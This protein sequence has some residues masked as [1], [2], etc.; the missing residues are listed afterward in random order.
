[1]QYETAESLYTQLE[2]Q[3]WTFLDR[4][5][6][7]SE[8]TIPY[9]LP[10]D[11]HG[12]HTKYYTPYQGIGARGVNNLASKLLLA[13]L[14]PNAPFFRLVIDRYEL[15]KAKA[16]MGEEGGEQLRT[17]L[18]KALS[19]VER[20]VSQEVEVE[21]FRVGVFE[22]LKNLLIT[23]NT[24]LY[25]PD[26]GGMRV[27]RPDR[28]V[29]KR[30]A[31]GNVT[32]IAVKETVAPF[33]LPEEVR[34]EVYKESKDNNCDL[35]TS[36]CREGDKFVVKQDVKGIVIEE[37]IGEYPIDKSP[38]LPLRYT[39]IDGEDY[40][41]GFVEEYLGDLKSLEAL[42]KAI[43]EGSAAAA[44]VLFMINPNGTTRARTLAEAPNGAIVQGSDG[45]VSV[46]QLNKFN[47][48]RVAQSVM[49]Q[50][51]DRLSHAFLL[52]SSVVRDA[53]RVTAEE[54]RMLSQELE[55]ALGGLYSILSQE[56]QLPLVTRLMD[57][58]S[59]KD[60]LPKLPKDIVKPTIVT[61]IEALGRGNDLN[62]LDMFLA[63]AN[64]VV[65]PQAVSQYVNVGD[66]F[67]RRATALGIETEGLIKSDEEIQ[68]AMQQAQQQEMMMK[69]GAPAVA[70]TIN[71]IAQQQQGE[72]AVEEEQ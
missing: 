33:M 41:R 68:M 25:L 9:V 43:V 59:K 48:F 23:G 10:P 60:N 11:G 24:L 2:G 3:R 53:E 50:I 22:A 71:A 37:S 62:R 14:P 42:T 4:G 16:D 46:L 27:F 39:R 58:M 63:G 65:G 21:A 61:G 49:A 5:R 28:Y 35:Y 12:P 54:I 64:Q 67:K 57:R 69:L 29:V 1:M 26:D 17:D 6:E 51:Q 45:D 36:I 32:H 20:A 34:Q 72:P 8:L 40:G 7:S 52:N 31:M 38:W 18:E 56:F 30:D 66:Y 47:D 15:E 55:S 13:L 19:D 70:P 44:K